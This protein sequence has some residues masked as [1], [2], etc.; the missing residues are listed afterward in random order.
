MQVEVN[1][2]NYKFVAYEIPMMAGSNGSQYNFPVNN[3]L[4]GRKVCKIV[5]LTDEDLSRSP[6]STSNVVWSAAL[7]RTATITMHAFD[8]LQPNNNGAKGD[9][10]KQLPCTMLHS[11]WTNG[12]ATPSQSVYNDTLFNN[13][14]P[15]WNNSFITFV[16]NPTLAVNTSALFGVWY[17]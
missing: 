15:D 5:S 11:I 16:V 17:I 6:I 12:G 14:L 2:P 1:L 4:T 8:P 3:Y 13:L 7:M 10:I 9:W